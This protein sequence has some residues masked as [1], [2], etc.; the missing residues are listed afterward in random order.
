MDAAGNPDPIFK[1]LHTNLN[2][3]DYHSVYPPVCQVIFLLAVK[4]F[5]GSIYWSTVFMK[6][7]ILAA[8]T[9]SIYILMKFLPRLGIPLKRVLLYALNPLVIIELSGNLHFEAIMIFFLLA[10]LWAFFRKRYI[11]FGA[12]MALSIGTKLLP[13]IFLPFFIKRMRF[14]KLAV[15]MTTLGLILVIL[16]M[17]FFDA[18][19]FQGF[20]TSLDLYFRKF[21]FNGSIYYVLRWLGFHWKGYNIIG[22]LGPALSLITLVVVLGLAVF[23]SR[24]DLKH[25][26]QVGLIGFSCYLFFSTTIHPWY[27]CIPLVL[28]LFTYFRYPV[29]WS[30]LIFLT[31][32]NYSYQPYHENLWIVSIEYIAVIT[33]FI[34]E[35]LKI[36]IFK[37]SLEAYTKGLTFLKQKITR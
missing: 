22:T 17:P 20:S 7:F 1:Q 32:I 24:T 33:L 37:I 28:S 12:L 15:S 10:A 11:L 16:F 31:Y 6:I 18:S 2:S 4:I 25:F 29:F 9:A 3:P 23:E 8:E 30:G 21:E 19:F 34:L 13:L 14:S 26:F 27:L 35:V 36:P 5:P